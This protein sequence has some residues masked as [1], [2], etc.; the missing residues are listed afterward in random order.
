[1][2]LVHVHTSFRKDYIEKY[3]LKKLAL[4]VIV[5]AL[6]F[7]LGRKKF[8]QELI[9]NYNQWFSDLLI[10]SKGQTKKNRLTVKK[11]LDNRLCVLKRTCDNA[12]D[13]LSKNNIWLD[14]V[15]IDLSF[16]Y[17]LKGY[18]IELSVKKDV[19]KLTR[20][21]HSILGTVDEIQFI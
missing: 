16:L 20:P 13:T 11:R 10:Q 19:D 2:K 15:D 12:D 6:G 14:I 3:K 21:Y 8:E 17:S 9:T 4:A 18:E 5:D 7:H 1:M